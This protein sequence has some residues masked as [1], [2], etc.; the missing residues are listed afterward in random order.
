MSILSVPVPAAPVLAGPGRSARRVLMAMAAL[1]TAA[2]PACSPPEPVRPPDII[3]V[4]LDTAR[5]D[6]FSLYGYDRPTTPAFDALAAECVRFDRAYSTSCWT[7]PSHASLF[8]GLY[9]V[10]HGANQRSQYLD[11]SAE[12]LAERLAAAGYQTASFS[13]NPWISEKAN[14]AQGFEHAEVVATGRTRPR[15]RGLPHAL[16]DKA[17]AWLDARDAARP[18]FLFLNYIEPHWKYQAPT[19]FQRKFLGD[20][21]P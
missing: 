21:A 17:L 8:T 19:E 18:G 10:A 20:A 9:P 7:V 4:V 15:G 11:G 2:V 1:L 12:T 3:V 14:L 6:H 13:S 16:N 5:R